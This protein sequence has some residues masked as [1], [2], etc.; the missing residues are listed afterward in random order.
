M[1]EASLAT[2]SIKTPPHSKDSEMMVL[3]CMLTS[4]NALNIA[5]GMLSDGDFY[6]TEHK[7]LFQVL[8]EAYKKDSP[9]DVHLVAEELKRIDRLQTVGGVGYLMT[10]AQ[11]V[12]TTAHIEEYANIVKAQSTLRR[13]ISAAQQV[14]KH[15]LEQPAD[16][17]GALDH[18]QNLFFQI[19][20]TADLKPGILLRELLGG[21]RGIQT[22]PF[23]RELE[24]RHERFTNRG[25]NDCGVTG[26]PTH[27]YDLDKLINGLEESSL[28]ILAGRT[29]IGK[30]TLALNIAENVCFQGNKAV[31]FISLEMNAQQIAT[32]LISSQ[33]GVEL[34]KIKTGNLTA[35][36]YQDIVHCVSAMQ[37]RTFVIDHQPGIKITDLRARARRMYE[38]YGIELLIIDYLQL[39]TGSGSK[40]SLEN[41][42]NEVA[43]ISRLLKMLAGEL[44]IP[45]IC[46]SQLSRK[47]DERK[48]HQPVLSD[49][50]DSGA[51][52]YDADVVCFLFRN[53]YY[54]ERDCSGLA[55]VIV[56]KNRHGETGVVTLVYRKE[57][58]QFNNYSRYSSPS[59]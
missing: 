46:L 28:I 5:A 32:R 15:A 34:N 43:E 24:E 14:E 27:F 8:K 26:I 19:G 10:L 35:E 13:I 57:I 11:Y 3:G 44:Q 33:S 1:S 7:V 40:I 20:K 12:G 42:Q 31:G 2:L 51:I 30:T 58:S 29:G 41:R 23:L 25:P 48:D 59:S 52:E 4:T 16:V 38:A 49:L 47:I 39:I 36:E 21:T 54:D 9:A 45:V 17:L 18:A 22:I 53:G 50:K 56:A 37:S 6:Y 55:N